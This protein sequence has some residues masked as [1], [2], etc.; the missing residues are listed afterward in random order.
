MALQVGM[1]VPRGVG[2]P[3]FYPQ[4][5]HRQ[6]LRYGQRAE[7]LG[8]DS[9][10][11]GDHFF[12]QRAGGKLEPYHE[13][14]TT[15]TAL[16]M[17]T[18]RVRVGPMVLS[19]GFRHP[20]LLAHMAGALQEL[21]EGRLILGVGTGNQPIEHAVFGLGFEGRVARL[22]EYLA[23]L[24]AL[25]NNEHITLD[26][27]YYQVNDARLLMT[28]PK[29]PI[30]IAANGKR[31]LQLTARYAE[32]W[33]GAGAS[34]SDGEPFVSRLAELHEACRAI[35]R[36]PGKIEVSSFLLAIVSPDV[37][38]TA[39]VVAQLQ[40]L[41]GGISPE[42]VH[43]RYILGT[44]DQVIEGLRRHV[45]WGVTHLIVSLGGYPSSLWSDETLDLF[46][47][48]VLPALHRD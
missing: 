8:F 2:D 3:R 19:A 46:A 21:S 11:L 33:N 25:L 16:L 20:A 29:V 47:R 4:P 37:R 32:G 30:W 38:H 13:A 10:W 15:A 17:R 48:E 9:L 42:A 24:T 41:N 22:E 6:M 36:D 28:V 5:D 35:G 27:R 44:P 14:W 31:M 34:N 40:D 45:A 43:A 26:G 1:F 18:E 39:S 7:E 12:I 23:I